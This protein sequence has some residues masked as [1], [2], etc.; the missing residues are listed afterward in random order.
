MNYG[1]DNTTNYTTNYVA[2]R[3]R[4][5]ERVEPVEINVSNTS[6][7]SSSSCRASRAVLFDKL[8]S[9]KCMGSTC[10]TC[11]VVSSRDVTSQLEFGPSW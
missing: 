1:D 4:C 7:Q 3:S 10:R 5:V 6:S 8:D 2:S 9:G 11:R